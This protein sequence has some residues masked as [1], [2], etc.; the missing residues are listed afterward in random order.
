MFDYKKRLQKVRAE[1]DHI[2]A[3]LK[4]LRGPVDAEDETRVT[5]A[6]LAEAIGKLCEILI[7]VIDSLP[8]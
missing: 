3:E 2:N 6:K 4:P 8:G 7:R 5:V 1:L